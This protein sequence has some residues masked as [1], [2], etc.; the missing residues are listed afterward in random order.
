MLIFGGGGGDSAYSSQMGRSL[1]VGRPWR[2]VDPVACFA[3]AGAAGMHISGQKPSRWDVAEV[4]HRQAR[5]HCAFLSVAVV[6]CPSLC[7]DKEG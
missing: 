7:T 4:A 3:R 5:G 6:R 1:L 2:H